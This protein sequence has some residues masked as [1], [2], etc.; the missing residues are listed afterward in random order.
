MEGFWPMPAPYGHLLA[1]E[2][3][4]CDVVLLALGKG[5]YNPWQ[6]RVKYTEW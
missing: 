3:I 1:L 6:D 5:L 2:T 4:L